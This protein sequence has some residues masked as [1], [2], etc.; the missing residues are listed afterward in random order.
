[1]FLASDAG[2]KKNRYNRILILPS[3]RLGLLGVFIYCTVFVY[4][5]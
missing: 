3:N 2:A 5:G 4:Y 1:M